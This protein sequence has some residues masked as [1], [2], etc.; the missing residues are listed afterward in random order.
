MENNLTIKFDIDID[1]KI[2]LNHNIIGTSGYKDTFASTIKEDGLLTIKHGMKKANI[3]VS[4]EKMN[5]IAVTYS[6]SGQLKATFVSSTSEKKEN[7]KEEEHLTKEKDN[8]TSSNIPTPNVNQTHNNNGVIT[9]VIIVIVVICGYVFLNFDSLFGSSNNNDDSSDSQVTGEQEAVQQIET[10]IRSAGTRY[11]YLYNTYTIG[12]V[13]S[14]NCTYQ[15]YDNNGRYF[16]SCNYTY[17]PQNGAGSTM[18]DREHSGNVNAMFINNGDG[19]FYYEFGR[20][21]SA[22]ES[23][24]KS[25]TCWGKSESLKLNCD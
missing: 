14:A 10:L 21:G 7:N 12:K 16:L 15:D 17:N 6:T 3:R 1:V 2:Y 25:K 8:I 4:K 22:N 19:T 20:A 18:L 9:T 13:T 5:N 23:E 11:L 24:F